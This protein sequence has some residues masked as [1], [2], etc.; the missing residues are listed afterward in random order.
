MTS[1]FGAEPYESHSYVLCTFEVL[2]VKNGKCI[3]HK[4]SEHMLKLQFIYSHKVLGSRIRNL[5]FQNFP[6][7]C[8][9]FSKIIFI[10]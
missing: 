4:T 2:T 7:S 3:V 8:E 9:V 10:P 6:T 5:K 1:A